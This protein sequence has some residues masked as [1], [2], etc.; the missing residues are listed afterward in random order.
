MFLFKFKQIKISGKPKSFFLKLFFQISILSILLVLLISYVLY[1][2]YVKESTN[3][4][5]F[6]NQKLLLQTCSNFD[7]MDG[8]VR[9]TAYNISLNNKAIYLMSNSNEDDFYQTQ[10]ISDINEFISQ[11]PFINSIYLYNGNTSKY[12]CISEFA[13]IRNKSEMFDREIVGILDSPSSIEMLSPIARRIPFSD[14]EQQ[15]LEDVYTY[16]LYNLDSKTKKLNDAVV[17]NVNATYLFNILNATAVQ[18]FGENTS[19]IV[20]NK[21]GTVYGHTKGNQFKKNISNNDYI[22]R[23]L[24]ANDSSGFFYNKIENLNSV[25][26]YQYINDSDLIFVIITTNQHIIDFVNKIKLTSVVVCIC[27]VLLGLLLSYMLSI[28]FYSPVKNLYKNMKEFLNSTEPFP[29]AIVRKNEFEFIS[30][31]MT[32]ISGKMTHLE[33]FKS[34]S[35]QIIKQQY[36]SKLLSGSME[37]VDDIAQK[38][39]QYNVNINLDFKFI[40]I[41]FKIDHYND[42]INKFDPT[43]QSEGKQKLCKIIV[44]K[45][46]G[47]P[48]FEC[49]NLEN[50]QIVALV[51]V[52]D[53]FQLETS[54][55]LLIKEI[56][57]AGQERQALSL[58]AA[59][60]KPSQDIAHLNTIYLNTLNI[61]QYRLIYGNNCILTPELLDHVKFENI[62]FH[63]NHVKNLVDSLK[64]ETKEDVKKYHEEIFTYLKPYTPQSIRYGLVYL[65][66]NIFDTLNVIENNSTALFKVDFT[67]FSNKI[68]ELET[69]EEISQCFISLYE[70]VIVKLEEN[71]LN[72]SDII[73]NTVKKYIDDH[74]IDSNLS[75]TSIAE[76]LNM[77]AVYLG[78]QFKS[79]V[80]KSISEYINDV[81]ISKAVEFLHNSSYT[82]DDILEKVGWESKKYFFTVFKKNYGVTPNEYRLS[83]NIKL[84][85]L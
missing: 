2:N 77:N 83:S 3:T 30:N 80:F 62:E 68:N 69:L 1:S 37:I 25:V 75:L 36:L 19:M 38:F 73:I 70:M 61:L 11:I 78:K 35:M 20:M 24:S 13:M 64:N 22:K 60:S 48:N 82:I 58:S 16:I 26:N 29:N 84:I 59:V 74:Y 85:N 43:S 76:S 17:I 8:Y 23:I 33:S 50:D 7:F 44:E 66:I 42:F 14:Y 79:I 56:Q 71:K 34:S 4:I 57:A 12:Y 52:N 9:D 81:R 45:L 27:A 28:N 63:S 54:I 51:N 41:L 31:T 53:N 72:K 15:R 67:D 32:Q 40:L 55:I 39:I 49:I 10:Y 46:Y 5:S 21:N 65:T 47:M 18:Q 6:Y